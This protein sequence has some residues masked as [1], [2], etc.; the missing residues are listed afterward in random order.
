MASKVLFTSNMLFCLI[1]CSTRL[2][3]HAQ[4]YWIQYEFRHCTFPSDTTPLL[5]LLIGT[6]HSIQSSVSSRPPSLS[7][8]P[9][10]FS[11]YPPQKSWNTFHVP[12]FCQTAPRHLRVG[13]TQLCGFGLSHEVLSFL[14][15]CDAAA[16]RVWQGRWAHESKPR[17]FYMLFISYRGYAKPPTH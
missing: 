7:S 16:A 11:L 12:R 1:K 4:I 6:P 3:R 5:V 13:S 10:R 2:L 9:P 15:L 14:D 8:N 17:C